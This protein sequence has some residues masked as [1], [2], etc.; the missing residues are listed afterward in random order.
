[1]G[2]D[3]SDPKKFE[4]LQLIAA[5]LGWTD[6][7]SLSPSHAFITLSTQLTNFSPEQREQAGLARPGTSSGVTSSLRLPMSPF[8]RTPSTPSLN[9]MS[10]PML[11]ASSSSN[12]ESLAELWQDFL[13]REAG[14]EKGGE[15]RGSTAS[16]VVRE[17]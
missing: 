17:K 6:G 10:D 12:K 2:L 1:M 5:L 7:M 8:R 9:S 3:R 16:S 15:R 13:E 11:M 4:S 14:E